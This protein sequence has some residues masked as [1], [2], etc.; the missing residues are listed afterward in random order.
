MLLIFADL[1]LCS[2]PV[3]L[4][5]CGNTC[6]QNAFIQMVYQIDPL[7]DILSKPKNLYAPNTLGYVFQHLVWDI[8]TA[9]KNNEPFIGCGSIESPTNLKKFTEKIYTCIE[10]EVG[11]R[12]DMAAA[13]NIVLQELKKTSCQNVY[14]ILNM[15]R[16][17]TIYFPSEA[18]VVPRL[19]PS[20]PSIALSHIF[21]PKNL[22]NYIKNQFNKK[23]SATHPRTKILHKNLNHEDKLLAAPS[24]MAFEYAY[25]KGFWH[26]K[27]TYFPDELNF[28]YIKENSS[29]LYQLRAIGVYADGHYIAVVRD[30]DEKLYVCNDSSI[31]QVNS[32][33]EGIGA[34]APKIFLYVLK[35][36]KHDSSILITKLHELQQKLQNLEYTIKQ[37][38]R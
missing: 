1:K 21:G 12:G 5:N 20:M 6:F 26:L 7:I 38:S 14:S 16:E 8:A 25:W 37:I 13:F 10:L 36:R 17:T 27:D 4:A 19:V 2:K 3:G 31:W 24:F 11:N 28:P 23:S 34:Y 33:S 22:E 15:M 18:Y 9:Q 35:M 30:R 29:A 32:W